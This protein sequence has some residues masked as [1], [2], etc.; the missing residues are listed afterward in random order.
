MDM[1]VYC[2]KCL[3]QV[4]KLVNNVIIIAFALKHKLRW[5]FK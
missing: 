3:G 5:L 1:F 4:I 2:V